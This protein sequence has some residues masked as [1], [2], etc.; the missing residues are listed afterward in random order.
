MNENLYVELTIKNKKET[1]EI[2]GRLKFIED[3]TKKQ[4]IFK[5]YPSTID[6]VIID[7]CKRL[8]FKDD[9]DCLEK[10]MMYIHEKNLL[11][12]LIDDVK[13]ST[14]KPTLLINSYKNKILKYF[15]EE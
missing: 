12:K 7:V 2:T 8:G 10:T 1:I 9:R 3:N 15:K 11:L 5:L 14:L 6:W 13:G 4:T